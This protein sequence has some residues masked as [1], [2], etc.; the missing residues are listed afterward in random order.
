MKNIG[1]YIRITEEE[2]QI[3]K[4]LWQKHSINISSLIR[5]LILKHY[6]ELSHVQSHKQK[7]TSTT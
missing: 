2:N 7:Q 3:V 6:Q 5:D 1:L 4:E